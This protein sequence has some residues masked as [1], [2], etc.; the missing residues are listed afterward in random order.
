MREKSRTIDSDLS[1]LFREHLV[2]DC[3][4]LS[5][6]S[7]VSRVGNGTGELWKAHR[8]CRCGNSLSSDNDV[9][10]KW[11]AESRLLPARRDT[12][13]GTPP[14]R[15]PDH[16]RTSGLESRAPLRCADPDG[17]Q[18]ALR[19]VPRRN[20]SVARHVSSSDAGVSFKRIS[21]LNNKLYY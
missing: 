19:S 15:A 18:A 7:D 9:W 2:L 4:G 6:E 16:S 3:R 21:S 1:V 10:N 8:C 12:P 13:V 14:L 17:T 5:R 20:D 11:P